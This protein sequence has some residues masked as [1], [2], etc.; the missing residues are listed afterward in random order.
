MVWST[1]NSGK[2]RPVDGF[3]SMVKVMCMCACVRAYMHVNKRCPFV[4]QK[5]QTKHR[6]LVKLVSKEQCHCLGG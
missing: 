5:A 6:I 4:A 1:T 3:T 2:H